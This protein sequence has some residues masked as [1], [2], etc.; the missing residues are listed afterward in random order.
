MMVA[1]SNAPSPERN[2]HIRAAVADDAEAVAR[3]IN[4][5]FVVERVAFDGDRTNPENVRALMNTGTFLLAEDSAGLAGC[6]YV[7]VRGER[8]YLGLLSVDPQ[9][10]GTGLGRRLVG[11]MEEHSRSVGCDA[12]DLRVI[13]PRAE[14]VPFYRHLG[15]VET[16]TEGFS[17]DVK[18]KVPAHYIV[19]SKKLR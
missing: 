7:E 2:T 4:A 15:Y 18:A 8:S 9:R 12:V 6:V 5:A 3:L 16:G 19:M 10:Q 14:L 11:A 13:S 1:A 17:S